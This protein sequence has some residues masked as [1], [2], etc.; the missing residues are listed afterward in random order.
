[1]R[2]CVSF[3][4]VHTQ[5]RHLPIPDYV[6]YICDTL[7][8]AGYEAYVVGGGVRDAL[9]GRNPK[10]WDVA[11]SASPKQVQRLFSTTVAT[12][13]EFGTVTVLIDGGQQKTEQHTSTAERVVGAD[14]FNGDEDSTFYAVEV[15]TFREEANYTDGRRPGE[16]RFLD[17]VTADLSRRDFTVNA[18]AYDPL[19]KSIVDPFDGNN[20]LQEQILRAVGDPDARFQEDALRMLRAVRLA[21][22]LGFTLDKA[23]ALALRRNKS[24]LRKISRERIGQEWRRIITA[25]A[26]GRGLWLLHKFQLLPY[27]FSTIGA[28]SVQEGEED[29]KNTDPSHVL[30]L[31]QIEATV[32]ALER[33][34]TVE[35]RLASVPG[36]GEN[37]D[38]AFQ[39]KLVVPTALILYGAG[40]VEHHQRWLKGL[41]YSKKDAR[42]SLHLARLLVAFRP[43][44]MDADERLRRFLSTVGR[45][46][47]RSFF[48]A[49]AAWHAE[50]DTIPIIERVSQIVVR[51]DALSTKELTLNGAD[52]TTLLGVPA[53][54]IVGETL[55]RLLEHTF[56][57]PEDNVPERLAAIMRGWRK[58]D[59]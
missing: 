29:A 4:A 11:T 57:Y 18:I 16:V 22:E 25:P 58:R 49:W 34:S 26:A 24:A 55:Q 43:N 23:T 51:G 7:R 27:I 17:D 50:V 56:T 30:S 21:T 44:Q 41:V 53:G 13:I 59:G 5:M 32:A 47:I 40:R 28:T 36:F 38:G 15:T 20:D 14:T 12:G 45:E 37:G 35:S 9:L 33:L 6:R 1:M 39:E 48:Q 3:E 2:L 31:R 8:S 42:A 52:V 10:D 54:P 46:Y 19:D